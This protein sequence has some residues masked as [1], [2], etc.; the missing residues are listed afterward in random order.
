V[1]VGGTSCAAFALKKKAST[2]RCS[3][4]PRIAPPGRPLVWMLT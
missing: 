4:C 2:V 1:S 3:I